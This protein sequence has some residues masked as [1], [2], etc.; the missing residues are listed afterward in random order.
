MDCEVSDELRAEPSE[1]YAPDGVYGHYLTYLLVALP[2][3][4]LALSSLFG[5]RPR[6]QAA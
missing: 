4:W 3:A 2:R 1:P 5:K 6:S